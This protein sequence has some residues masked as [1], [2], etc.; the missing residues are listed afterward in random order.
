[1]TSW[2]E[3]ARAILHV[4]MD[5]FY[6]SVEQREDESLKGKPVIVGGPKDARGVVSAASYEARAFGIHS[7][8]PLRTA[9]RLCPHGVFLPGRMRLYVK[10]SREVFAIFTRYS[11]LVEPLSVDEA[12]LDLTGAERLFGGPVQA[13]V[14]LREAIRDELRLTA[15]VGVAPNKFVAKIA[16]DLE[17]P[18]GLVV[19]QPGTV[20]QFLAPLPVERMWGIGPKG[21]AALH[22]KGVYTFG[23]LSGSGVG[24]LRR[25]FGAN[26]QSLMDLAAGRDARPVVTGRAP[27]S[28]GHEITF[29]ENV[30]DDAVLHAT[31]VSL[32]DRVAVR[33]RKHGLRA[34]CV[35]LKVRYAPFRTIT[36]R[37]T[38]ETPTC[39]TTQLIETALHLLE[40]RTPR[41]GGPVRLIGISTSGFRAQTALFEEPAG[42]RQEAVDSAVDQVRARFGSNA[43]QRASV[44]ESGSP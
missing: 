1:M 13:A 39:A 9:G 35:T 43:V 34:G 22:D 25:V 32:T 8:M 7:A 23:D 29:R 44:I 26:A 3:G 31:L 20:E 40:H 18:D 37:K 33:L 24:R 28:V 10:V 2:P 4:D 38:L 21:A 6:A 16:S 17:K 14:Q 36:R 30:S 42:R 12:F 5:A 41:N 11:P 15:S 27:K 19:V